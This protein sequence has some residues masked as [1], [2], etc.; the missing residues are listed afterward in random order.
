MDDVVQRDDVG[1]FEVLQ[2]GDCGQSRTVA[3]SH[4]VGIL[5]SHFVS[6]FSL[7]RET[8]TAALVTKRAVKRNHL[9]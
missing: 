6:V 3:P 5:I 8:Q 2:Q 4:Y 1:V 9:L 7:L